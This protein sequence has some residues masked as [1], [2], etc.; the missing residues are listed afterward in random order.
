MYRLDD[1]VDHGG[2]TYAKTVASVLDKTHVDNAPVP[3]MHYTAA[4]YQ[5]H[6]VDVALVHQDLRHVLKMAEQ[7][8][9]VVLFPQVRKSTILPVHM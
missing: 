4:R 6:T 5:S 3:T 2:L 8:H 9:P 7:K 1:D